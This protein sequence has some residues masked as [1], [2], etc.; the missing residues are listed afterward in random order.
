[1]PLPAAA[2]PEKQSRPVSGRRRD[3]GNPSPQRWPRRRGL[4]VGTHQL[5]GPTPSPLHS[6]NTSGKEQDAVG[7]SPSPL[8]AGG[9]L[10]L[11]VMGK[12]EAAQAPRSAGR[13]RPHW[14]LSAPGA[15]L[16]LASDLTALGP[17]QHPRRAPPAPPGKMA[18]VEQLR[19]Q[20]WRRARPSAI[21]APSSRTPPRPARSR[22]RGDSGGANR[23]GAAHCRPK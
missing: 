23:T 2:G 20:P 7:P 6:S 11:G 17:A 4:R 22:I 3:D 12:D 21:L 14:Q 1:M 15:W 9:L 19:H 10:G 16:P 5:Q 13:P 8:G 18:P